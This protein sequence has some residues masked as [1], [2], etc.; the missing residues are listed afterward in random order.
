ML[1]NAIITKIIKLRKILTILKIKNSLLLLAHKEEDIIIH[2][3]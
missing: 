2:D 1:L 3:K